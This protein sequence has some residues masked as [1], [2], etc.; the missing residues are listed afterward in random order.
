MIEKRTKEVSIRKV[1]G[2][3]VS[4]ILVLLSHEYVRLIL[5]A[6][7]IAVPV[8]HYFITDWLGN[9]AYRVDVPWWV[10]VVPG[11]LVLV[12]ALL[13][14]S[15]QTLRAARRNPVDSLRYE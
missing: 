2:A 6:F 10:Y 12:V 14:V 15:A 3:S 7:A 13:S 11:L 5:I 8:A 1:L 9:Y 4:S